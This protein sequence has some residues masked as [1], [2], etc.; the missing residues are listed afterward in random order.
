M[1]LRLS[2]PD[3][4]L[5]IVLDCKTSLTLYTTQLQHTYLLLLERSTVYLRADVWVACR[6][7]A[8]DRHRP[9]R[10]DELSGH[11]QVTPGTPGE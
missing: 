3:K 5:P 2:S 7:A 4:V 8:G 6:L 9:T 1:H 10:I 11:L